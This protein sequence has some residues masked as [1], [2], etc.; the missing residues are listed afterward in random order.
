[1]GSKVKYLLY[2]PSHKKF[3]DKTPG[4]N[5]GV[6]LY[7]RGAGHSFTDVTLE[8]QASREKP[9]VVKGM[10]GDPEAATPGQKGS[11]RCPLRL[12]GSWPLMTLAEVCSRRAAVRVA[13]RAPCV[14]TQQQGRH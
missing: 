6:N 14:G 3:A 2:D 11:E 10:E 12:V 4:R 13:V 1:M 5:I 7:D 8:A 9:G